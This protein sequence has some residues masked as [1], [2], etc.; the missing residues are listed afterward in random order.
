MERTEERLKQQ[1]LPNFNSGEKIDR[2]KGNGVSGACGTLTKTCCSCYNP[3]KR[4]KTV[5]LKTYL[6]KYWLNIS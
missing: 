6:N 5:G 1:R 2:R 4:R 3:R